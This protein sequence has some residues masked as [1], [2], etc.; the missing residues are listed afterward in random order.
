[1][2]ESLKNKNQTFFS[3]TLTNSFTNR[4]KLNFCNRNTWNVSKDS[5]IFLQNRFHCSPSHPSSLSLPQPTNS[6]LTWQ[7]FIPAIRIMRGFWAQLDSQRTSSQRICFDSSSKQSW[8]SLMVF[9]NNFHLWISFIN[10]IL[11]YWKSSTIFEE[12]R[13]HILTIPEFD[14]PIRI[15]KILNLCINSI[16]SL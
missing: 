16:N 10:F 13:V 15:P 6:I 4:P 9:Y 3:E 11:F 7:R 12:S 5:K 2:R 14:K 8:L 1:M